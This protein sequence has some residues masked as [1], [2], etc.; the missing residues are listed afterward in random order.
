MD[1]CQQ[2][3]V[4]AFDKLSSFVIAFLSRCKWLLISWLQSPSAVILE[5]KKTK[6]LPVSIVSPS[7]C[8]ELWY[9]KILLCFLSPGN[10]LGEFFTQY[11]G[12]SEF[13]G[14]W[15]QLGLEISSVAP[16]VYWQQARLVVHCPTG[17]ELLTQKKLLPLCG[18][19]LWCTECFELRVGKIPTSL[20]KSINKGEED[21]TP[22]RPGE[23]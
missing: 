15:G 17:V 21:K 16:S 11:E 1:L 2:S 23:A 9:Y 5:P 20:G 3:N 4:S 10:N 12:R 13:R 14:K 22:G 6:F 19:S 7:I 8:H 18:M